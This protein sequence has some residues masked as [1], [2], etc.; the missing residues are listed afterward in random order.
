MT[1]ELNKAKKIQ[2][3]EFLWLGLYAFA[4]FSMEVILGV[5]VN[6]FGVDS[7]SKG[8]HSILTGFIWF[9]VSYLLI[10]FSKRKFAYDIFSAK[11]QLTGKKLII[12]L[13]LI[14]IITIAAFIGFDGF[15]PLVEFN[16]GSQGNLIT[17]LLQIFYYLGESG[18]IVLCIA[19][20]QRFFHE[21]FSI[22]DKI[23]SGGLFLAMTWGII[24]LF[25][26]GISGGLF[27]IFFSILAGAI[28]VICNKD[29]RMSYLFIA[30]AFIL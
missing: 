27:T 29:F 13:I 14:A 4:G 18:L 9:A 10:H 8:G 23:P 28:Y 1:S 5:V 11:H 19:F 24:H 16:N 30:L 26:Q 3:I 12:I 21:Q 6:L 7:L 2:P 22:S 20:G 15:K 25:L 17:Y